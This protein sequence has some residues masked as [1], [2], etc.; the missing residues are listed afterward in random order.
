MLAVSIFSKIK[1][2]FG[3][4][5]PL[6]TLFETLTIRNLATRI[7]VELYVAEGPSLIE[8]DT[9]NEELRF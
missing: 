5:L 9:D 3:V 4:D 8:G 7:D 1:E 6:A 2:I